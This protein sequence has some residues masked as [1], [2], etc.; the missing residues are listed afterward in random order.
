MRRI[1]EILRLRCEAGLS[2]RAIARAA[3]V[4]HSTVSGLFA[5][6]ELAGLTWPLPDGTTD[7]ELE[8]RLYR[9]RYQAV[10]DSREPDWAQVHEELRRHKHVTLR[11]SGSP[12]VPRRL[13]Y[14]GTRSAEA[15]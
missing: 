4:S 10:G 7:A 11:L 5:R 3:G 2:G 8:Q 6:A 12:R 13:S 9:D 14:L 1:R 15:C